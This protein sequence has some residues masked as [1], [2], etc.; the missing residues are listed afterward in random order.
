M[1]IAIDLDDTI[2]D[3]KNVLS[4]YRMGQPVQGA[5]TSIRRLVT[6]GHQIFIFTA[7]NV[8]DP[9]VKKAV[10]DWLDHFDIPYSGI[11]NIKSPHFQVFID[12]RAIQ[13]DT[14]PQTLHR[15]TNMQNSDK[16]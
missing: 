14:W 9:R 13:F 12:N 11:T 7:R 6:E 3:S 1:I 15:L 4:G 10:A 16:V 2:I 8:Q 5:I